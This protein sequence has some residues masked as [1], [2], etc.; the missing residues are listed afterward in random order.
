MC[1]TTFESYGLESDDDSGKA[2]DMNNL[3]M[4][5]Q[6]KIVWEQTEWMV[7]CVLLF[8]LHGGWPIS[9][10]AVFPYPEP[11]QDRV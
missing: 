10:V 7:F 9:V 6:M 5:Q 2:V 11:V 3:K 1:L 4:S 8:T